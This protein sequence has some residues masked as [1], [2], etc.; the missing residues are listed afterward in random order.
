VVITSG[1]NAACS[2]ML[3]RLGLAFLTMVAFGIQR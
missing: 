2:A 1:S 3:I